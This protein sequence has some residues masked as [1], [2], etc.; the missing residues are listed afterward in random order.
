MPPIYHRTQSALDDTAQGA[1]L[2]LTGASLKANKDLLPPPPE[3]LLNSVISWLDQGALDRLHL[4]DIGV[5]EFENIL[6]NLSTRGVKV[7]YDWDRTSRTVVI[8]LVSKLHEVPGGWF[9]GEVMPRVNTHLRTTTICGNPSVASIGSAGVELGPSTGVEGE[10][11]KGLL[12]DQSLDLMQVDA[13]GEEISVQLNPRVVIETSA[14]ESRQHMMEKIF[15]YLYETN[16]AV[17]AVVVC[18]LTNVP[19]HTV[20]N[21]ASGTRPTKPFK[22]EIAVW[23]RRKT[24]LPDLDGPL[25]PCYHR[26]E[27]GDHNLG[28]V[29]TNSSGSASDSARAN[30]LASIQIIHTKNNGYI[31]GLPIG[32]YVVLPSYSAVLLI[33]LVLSDS[34]LSNNRML[35]GALAS[36]YVRS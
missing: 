30:M 19:P 17:H 26:Q 7:R 3:K 4:K 14:S 6:Q 34:V 32:L 29:A 33:I 25:D 23:T 13:N 36:T 11:E 31:A 21:V 27:L 8:R 16:Y 12:P 28:V 18:D 1:R 20:C 9:V 24:G 22:A 10:P 2:P 35:P 15:K 5:E